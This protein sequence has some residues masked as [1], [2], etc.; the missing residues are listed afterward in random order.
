ME[1]RSLGEDAYFAASNSGRGFYSDYP[2]C[3]DAARVGRVY[4]VKGGPGTGKSRFLRDVAEYGEGMGW[5]SEYVY[6]SS[7]PDSLDGVILSRGEACIALLDATAP[8]VYEPTHPGVRE[9][10]V[11]LGAFWDSD[12]LAARA[13]EIEALN[14]QKSAAYRR[15]Y[16]YLAGMEQMT[17]NRDALAAPYIRREAIRA[18]AEKLMK[19]VEA[20]REY[21]VQPALM[22]S[23]G[24][25]GEVGFDTYF[26]QA[27]SIVLIEDCRGSAQYLMH[28]I[29]QI[30]LERRL[31][32]RLS[33]DPVCP[34]RIDAILLCG[35]GLCFA[36]A[37]PTLCAYPFKCVHMRRFV[38]TAGL[39]AVR[40]E[41]LFAERMSRA[42]LDGATEALRAVRELHFQLEA[43]Y[44]DAMDFAA[45]ENFTKIFCQRLFGLQNE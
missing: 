41:L 18:F 38:N 5:K 36:V 13:D 10:L 27:S 7:D 35:S 21:L 32:I 40:G 4:A 25:R 1:M 6:C 20:E 31:H 28:D 44:I 24:M 17:Q 9:E 19:G 45:K 43:L 33:H 34:D 37:S 3:F 11:N 30:A 14:G 22:R 39:K 26:A 2:Q 42:M 15:A 8:H 23:V 29:G 12:A 16:R